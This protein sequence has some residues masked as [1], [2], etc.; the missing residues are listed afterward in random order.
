MEYLEDYKFT[1]AYHPGKANVVANALS[2]KNYGEVACLM[3]KRWEM[4]KVLAEYGVQSKDQDEKGCLCVIVATP[5]LLEKVIEAQR[6]DEE[7]KFI[8]TGLE[9][10]EEFPYWTVHSDGSLRYAGRIFVPSDE[11]LREEVLKEHHCSSFA[12]HPGGTKMYQ[13]LKLQY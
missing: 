3:I 11:E 10:G 8:K 1:L 12:V 13:D 5:T 4:I 9:A 7:S 2:R 6:K